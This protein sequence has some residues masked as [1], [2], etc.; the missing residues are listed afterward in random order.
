MSASGTVYSPGT[1]RRARLASWRVASG[2]RS[3]IGEISSKGTAKHVV[4]HDR[5]PLWRR[6]RLEHDQ[7]RQADRVGQQRFA[8]GSVPVNADWLLRAANGVSGAC[9]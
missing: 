6:H 8:L 1:R 9:Q 4:E 2:E 7:Q 5:E 3:T